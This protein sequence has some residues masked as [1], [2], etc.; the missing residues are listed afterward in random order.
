MKEAH[1][2]M[3]ARHFYLEGDLLQNRR[4]Y[5]VS[6][7]NPEGAHSDNFPLYAWIIA[8]LWKLTGVSVM[9]ARI[10]TILLSLGIVF[11]TYLIAK[12]LFEKEDLALLSAFV[13]STL[14]IFV[15]FGRTV[16]YDVPALFFAVMAIYFFLI[17]KKDFNRNYLL[18]FVIS[19]S[20]AA[21]TKLVYLVYLFPIASV[22]PYR[23]VFSKNFMKKRYTQYIIGLILPATYFLYG[24]LSN[25]SRA[26]GFISRMLRPEQIEKV[27][28]L[29]FW[30]RI[31][32]FA[33]TDNFTVIGFWIIILGL[34]ISLFLFKNEANRMLAVWVFSIIPYAF[35]IGWMLEG[36]NYYQFP[37]IPVAGILIGYALIF[38]FNT[39][40]S[41]FSIG[42][43][44]KN[45]LKI[46]IILLF[47]VIFMLPGFSESIKR[48]FD[49]QFFGLEV[50][51]KYL[52]ENSL[53]SEKVFGSG[54]QDTGFYWHAHRSGRM[55][56]DDIERLKKLEE[57]LSFNWVFLYSW[58]IAQANNNKEVWNYLLNNYEPKQIGFI[59]KGKQ[60]Q[61][62][63]LLLKQGKG[64]DQSNLGNYI[65]PRTL[66]EK[67]YELTKGNVNLIYGEAK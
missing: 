66:N 56:P 50:A 64:F 41:F 11:F 51:G 55:L 12:E 61:M 48:Q 39:A 24:F 26:T 5:M 15:F 60:T 32:S 34:I 57:K 8:L 40:L 31:F 33:V 29:S 49:T 6:V 25:N 2:L 4:D 42:I 17:W 59:K 35:I 38:V 9:W 10:F 44:L 16:F 47:L 22:F 43:R 36:H 63:Y 46:S 37:F 18:V 62:Y 20:L 14:P 45:I 27:T 7:E 28:S 19:I 53:P 3:E 1:T 30:G 67:S 65:D 13:T 58:G 54:H 21:L 52:N 23:K